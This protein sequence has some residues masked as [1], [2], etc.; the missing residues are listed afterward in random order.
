MYFAK[1]GVKYESYSEYHRLTIKSFKQSG[2]EKCI[3]C[4]LIL[5]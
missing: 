1:V 2:S 4:L 5:S 3:S